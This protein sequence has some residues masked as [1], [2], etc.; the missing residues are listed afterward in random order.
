MWTYEYAIGYLICIF[1]FYGLHI[2]CSTENI[3]ANKIY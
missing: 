2:N 3:E 1:N